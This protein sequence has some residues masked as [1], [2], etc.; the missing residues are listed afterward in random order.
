MSHNVGVLSSQEDA[1]CPPRSLNETERRYS[2]ERTKSVEA[3]RSRL[4]SLPTHVARRPAVRVFDTVRFASSRVGDKDSVVPCVGVPAWPGRR[5]QDDAALG[6]G[7][8]F[9]VALS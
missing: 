6:C 4:Q 1:W 2:A 9:V 8:G 5:V 3:E 7:Q